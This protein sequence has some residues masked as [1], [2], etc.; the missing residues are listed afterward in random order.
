MLIKITGKQIVSEPNNCSVQE[1]TGYTI[2]FT[3]QDYRVVGMAVG[4]KYISCDC[5][6]YEELLTEELYELQISD[7]GIYLD[8]FEDFLNQ[9][10]SEK[11]DE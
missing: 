11:D 8:T 9:I 2:H 3:Y 5:Y 4:T 6:P 1:Q 7:N 10:R